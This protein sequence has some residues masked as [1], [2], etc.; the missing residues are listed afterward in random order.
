[1][2]AFAPLSGAERTSRFMST[3][4]VRN[5]HCDVILAALASFTAISTSWAM[6]ASK[7]SG[8][9]IIGST[10]SFASFS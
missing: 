1:M 2:S 4:L 6:R 10:P 3:S 9:M 7:S 5:P 8:R